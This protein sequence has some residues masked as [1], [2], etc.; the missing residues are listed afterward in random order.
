MSF[1]TV[2]GRDLAQKL[3][4]PIMG[5]AAAYIQANQ[6][7]YMFSSNGFRAPT[8]HYQPGASALFGVAEKW[9]VSDDYWTFAP[10][11]LIANWY[12]TTSGA[13]GQEAANGN[14][15]TVE[16][17]S[18]QVGLAGS[19]IK[20]SINSSTQ[21]Y[22]LVDDTEIWTDANTLIA[23]PPA[24]LCC[25]RT[26]WSVPTST[27]YLSSPAQG[28]RPRFGDKAEVGT[29]SLADKV[30]AGGIS[31]TI[32]SGNSQYPFGPCAMV[33]QGWDGRP[34]VL[35][36]GTS[37]E[38]G[39]G[40]SR[41]HCNRFGEAGPIG[42]GLTSKKNGA[43]R[44]PAANWAVS[45]GLAAG[46]NGSSGLSRRARAILAISKGNPRG[47]LPFTSVYSG[48]GTNDQTGTLSTWIS[49]MTTMWQAVKAQWPSVPL[50]QSTLAPRIA[51][52][53]GFT[54][55]TNQ[56]AQSANWTYS[57]GSAWGLHEYFISGPRN[58]GVDRIINSL[59]GW[60]KYSAGGTRY[61][62]SLP[63]GFNSGWSTTLSALMAAAATTASLVAA[64]PENSCI[65]I[66]T[67]G[68]PE[69]KTILTVTQPG[70]N[71]SPF[72]S[73]LASSVTNSHASGAIVKLAIGE[74]GIHPGFLKA[75]Q[76][77]EDVYA[78]AINE[79]YFS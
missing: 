37:I 21:P 47:A 77:G 9:F 73:S 4:D 5:P 22:T 36:L 61:T 76:V 71:A 26:A 13:G 42:L 72:S 39:V 49:T 41:M 12:E 18:L 17:M 79:G 32:P 68:T 70:S 24:T 64:A 52:T 33:A 35:V 46:I 57:T 20:L 29:S 43:P 8:Q 45:G 44:V 63:A 25:V 40:Q 67:G 15:T 30:M 51:S 10:R 56:S 23:I 3:I 48:F 31:T 65:A 19:P 16:A 75:L 34:V 66:D 55:V 54:T 38:Q 7:R 69:S 6:S 28:I 74:D 27:S 1:E 59:D 11:F 50:V 62:W 2:F 53:D 60:D 58:V 14:N 78:P